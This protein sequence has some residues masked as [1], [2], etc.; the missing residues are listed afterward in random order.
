MTKQRTP[1]SL[2]FT[3]STNIEGL[4]P[5]AVVE[6]SFRTAGSIFVG[7]HPM[8]HRI[9]VD[10]TAHEARTVRDHLTKLLMEKPPKG[11][12]PV[13]R[14]PQAWEP[15]TEKAEYWRNKIAAAAEKQMERKLT[16]KRSR[17]AFRL[18]G[19]IGNV[20][21]VIGRGT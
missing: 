7:I 17:F 2:E 15:D 16:P 21:F 9:G 11:E 18:V 10:L 4:E 5:I 19:R 8:G 20:E 14:A 6:P 1:L 13:E 12:R 3:P